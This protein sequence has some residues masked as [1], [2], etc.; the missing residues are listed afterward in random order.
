MSQQ[1]EGVI[2]V[3]FS[4]AHE[5][6]ELRDELEKHLSLLKRE[7]IIVS[8]HDRLIGAGQEWDGLINTHLNTAAVI[9]LL[10]SADFL[11]SDYCWGVEVQ[12]A[13]QRHE[14]GE[15]CVI[16]TARGWMVAS[17]A[18]LATRLLAVRSESEPA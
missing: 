16:R 11:A 13:L 14:A 12:R 17:T 8:W 3:F 4:Y 9:L 10:V 1:S 7:G 6:K 5:D 15:A 2:E 18:P